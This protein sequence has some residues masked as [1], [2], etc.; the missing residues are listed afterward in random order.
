L[1]PKV[2]LP[3]AVVVGLVVVAGA[4]VEAAM[5]D[6]IRLE[7]IVGAV[8]FPHC[9]YAFEHRMAA[10]SLHSPFRSGGIGQSASKIHRSFPYSL[11]LN[12]YFDCL[13]KILTKT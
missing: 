7:L 13:D 12:H 2:D 4:V 11:K 9:Q 8:E 5:V 10:G 3:E 6:G 1:T